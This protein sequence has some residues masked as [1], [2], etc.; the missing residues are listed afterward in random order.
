MKVFR[1]KHILSSTRKRLL[2]YL[3]SKHYDPE[4]TASIERVRN[5]WVLKLRSACVE[6]NM[7]DDP[8]PLE[9]SVFQDDEDAAFGERESF[10]QVVNELID[11]YGLAGSRYD[12]ERLRIILTPG[13]K[14]EGPHDDEE[15]NTETEELIEL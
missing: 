10:R 3:K 12:K 15:G 8:D 5:G 4:W 11:Y 7:D 2:K 14:W 13:D 6:G 9:T 1:F